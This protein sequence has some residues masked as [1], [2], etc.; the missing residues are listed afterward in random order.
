MLL[1][2]FQLTY[3]KGS[4]HLHLAPS[5]ATH[6]YIQIKLR[7]FERR[8]IYWPRQDNSVMLPLITLELISVSSSESYTN[9]PDFLITISTG[10]EM[11]SK[12]F[13]AIS[14]SKK[15]VSRCEL[16]HQQFYSLASQDS[17]ILH[18]QPVCEYSP[19]ITQLSAWND[20]LLLIK[21]ELFLM[22]LIN[23]KN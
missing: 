13:P 11:H 18:T 8:C 1:L 10:K 5:L 19:T 22:L 3:S 12:V 14:P 23:I 21:A 7:L 6:N 17:K 15:Q 4:Q 2:A 16:Q 9:S 20:H